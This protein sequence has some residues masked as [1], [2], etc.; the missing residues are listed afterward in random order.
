MIQ[1]YLSVNI[2]LQVCD[3]LHC[4]MLLFNTA[5]IKSMFLSQAM[6]EQC[7][8]LHIP[9]GN[10]PPDPALFGCDLFYAR[11]LIK[12]NHILWCSKSDR[13]DLGGKEADDHRYCCYVSELLHVE[14]RQI[15]SFL[16]E[17]NYKKFCFVSYGLVMDRIYFTGS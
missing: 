5:N 11:H 10:I 6:I 14:S 9:V 1:H 4:G 15:V 12:H 2:N 13:P 7:R 3:L 16:F 17:L 8:Y